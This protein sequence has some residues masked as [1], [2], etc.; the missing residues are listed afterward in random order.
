M[1][2]GSGHWRD[3]PHGGAMR[4]EGDVPVEVSDKGNWQLDEIQ[5]LRDAEGT[6]GVKLTWMHLNRARRWQRT[7]IT[8][9][10]RSPGKWHWC[11]AKVLLA[12]CDFCG[13]EMGERWDDDRGLPD[14]VWVCADCAA[15]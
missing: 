14:P 12:A 5:I 6:S 8:A 11:T 4:L 10:F 13:I 15:K 3:L 1:N 9:V 2:S 7:S